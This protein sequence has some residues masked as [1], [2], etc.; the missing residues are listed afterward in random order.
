MKLDFEKL[1][2][3]EERQ[4][5]LCAVARDLAERRQA[6]IDDLA[7]QRQGVEIALR[8]KDRNNPG[9]DAVR[10]SLRCGEERYEPFRKAIEGLEPF[11]READRLTGLYNAAALVASQHGAC[12][13]TLQEYVRQ[14]GHRVPGQTIRTNPPPAHAGFNWGR[15]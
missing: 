12:L 2:R 10:E 13:P 15:S 8:M 5:Q 3:L 6:A 1:T 4:R 9:L 14:Q 7:Q 11:Q